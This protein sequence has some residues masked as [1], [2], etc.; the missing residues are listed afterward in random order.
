MCR[1]DWKLHWKKNQLAQAVEQWRRDWKMY[2]PSCPADGTAHLVSEGGREEE[3]ES[4][5]D[6]GRDLFSWVLLSCLTDLPQWSDFKSGLMGRVLSPQVSNR[7]S[8]RLFLGVG[9]GLHCFLASVLAGVCTWGCP[10][11]A[12]AYY[13]PAW[14]KRRIVFCFFRRRRHAEVVFDSH[15]VLH[16]APEGQSQAG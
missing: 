10:V 8:M 16:M 9:E 1:T 7:S 11:S 5:T 14:W 4:R 13:M 6:R 15:T 12:R 3:W 2:F